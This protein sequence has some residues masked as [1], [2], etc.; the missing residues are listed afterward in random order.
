MLGTAD[1]GT[2]IEAIGQK[3]ISV[4]PLSLDVTHGKTF[5]QLKELFS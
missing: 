2:D 5:E 3:C 4:T 1:P